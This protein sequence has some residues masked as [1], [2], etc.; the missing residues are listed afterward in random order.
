MPVITGSDKKGQYHSWGISG[1]RYYYNTP[2]GQ[3]MAKNKAI[4]QGKAIKA[5]KN[6]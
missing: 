5:S 3:T 4:K 6:K 1:K 2:K